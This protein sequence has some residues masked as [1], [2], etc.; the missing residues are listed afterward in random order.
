MCWGIIVRKTLKD[1]EFEIADLGFDSAFERL[2]SYKDEG[3]KVDK[4]IEKLQKKQNAYEKEYARVQK[5]CE[6]ERN[7]YKKGHRFIGGIDEVGRGPLAG[8][9]VAACVILPE[10]I[11][12]EGIN[13]SKQLSAEKR[14]YLY[15]LIREKAIS[16]GIGMVD[17]K[18]IDEVNILNATYM[19]MEAAVKQ[20]KPQ[21][22][23][24]LNDAVKLNNV[25]IEQIPII[26][27][28]CLSIS[29]A[30][31]SIIAKV[32]RDRLIEE[33]DSTYPEYGFSKNKGY[34]TKEHIEAIKKY[35][36]CPIHRISFT[37]NFV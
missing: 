4:L 1:I 14:D 24:L 16:Y 7:A 11:F 25:E 22:D 36:I 34:G 35:G 6:Y 17:E 31:A 27:G 21:P 29:I 20:L 37:K 2:Y 10:N 19:A 32:T 26:K 30:A 15:D 8:P 33:M 28:D 23:L 9:V 12:I 5:M 3:C 18:M 13:D